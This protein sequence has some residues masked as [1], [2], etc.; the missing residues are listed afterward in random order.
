MRYRFALFITL[1]LGVLALIQIYIFLSL[2][3][4]LG[5]I[6][7]SPMTR[8]II[9][10]TILGIA[11]FLNSG[12]VLRLFLRGGARKKFFRRFFHVPGFLWMI[13]VVMSFLFLAVKDLVFAIAGVFSTHLSVEPTVQA[14]ATGLAVAAPAILTGY[15]ALK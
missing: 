4:A 6:S 8:H 7:L 2:E 12:I 5:E 3:R 11:L 15:G 13:T 9:L 10:D 14:A 1:F